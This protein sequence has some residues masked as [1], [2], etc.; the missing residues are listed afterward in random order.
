MTI[1][2]TTII[3]LMAIGF[4]FGAG[5]GSGNSPGKDQAEGTGADGGGAGG[6]K[7]IA[8]IIVRE[9]NVRLETIRGGAMASLAEAKANLGSKMMEKRSADK[10]EKQEAQ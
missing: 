6:I 7:P 1:D 3:P 9:K 5:G 8:A 2:R 4:G 10:N